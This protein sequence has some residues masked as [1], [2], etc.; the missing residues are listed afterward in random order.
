MAAYNLSKA[1]IISLSETLYA[2]LAKD[3][4]GVSVL[5]P[6]FFQT[7]LNDNGRF[8]REEERLVCELSM[9]RATFTAADVANAA[10]RAMRKKQL[11]V[12]LPRKG[13]VW[14]RLKRAIPGWFMYLIAERYKQ[15]LPESL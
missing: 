5:C 10:I 15:G 4:I 12:L 11:Y 3:N 9:E 2:E 8:F 1:A 13:R 6:S 7:N 14:W